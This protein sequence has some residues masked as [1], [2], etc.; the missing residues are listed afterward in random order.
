M[1]DTEEWHLNRGTMLGVISTIIAIVGSLFLQT[2]YV[3]SYFARLESRVDHLEASQP[4]QDGRIA[5]LE[6]IAS[7]VVVMED[8]QI[9]IQRRLEVQTT[10]LDQLLGMVL[11]AKLNKQP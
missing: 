1:T 4:T 8:R 10:K 5:A 7:R 3:T 2:V 9:N 11:N 6:A